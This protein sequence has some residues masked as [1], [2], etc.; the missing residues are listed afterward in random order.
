[1]GAYRRTY[2]GLKPERDGPVCCFLDVI[3]ANQGAQLV[4]G[5]RCPDRFVECCGD[6]DHDGACRPEPHVFMLV[7]GRPYP[8]PAAVSGRLFEDLDKIAD[9]RF[10]VIIDLKSAFGALN[11]SRAI[12]LDCKPDPSPA[13]VV[14]GKPV[15]V[16]H[17]QVNACRCYNLH[18]PFDWGKFILP[19]LVSQGLDICSWHKSL[20]LV[21]NEVKITAA[22]LQYR[23]RYLMVY[24]LVREYVFTNC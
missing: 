4:V 15:H 1:M 8:E 17:G 22:Y 2:A 12:T 24:W 13:R 6:R 21:L 20:K 5:E 14:R 11:F 10:T 18:S 7:I 16:K 23:H 3:M 9:D 19:F